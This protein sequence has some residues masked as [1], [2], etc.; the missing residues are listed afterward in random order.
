M[1]RLMFVKGSRPMANVEVHVPALGERFETD[2]QGQTQIPVED[3]E[4]EVRIKTDHGFLEQTVTP[5]PRSSMTVVNVTTQAGH[6]TT[7]GR[8]DGYLDPEMRLGDRYEYVEHLGRGG[9]AVVV[10]ARDTVLER[11]VAIKILSRDLAEFEEAREIFMTEARNLATLSHSNLVPVYDVDSDGGR[12]MMITEYVQ[13][14]TLE[15]LL[16]SEAALPQSTALRIG[17]QLSRAVGY[18]HEEGT[19]HRDLKPANIMLQSDGTLKVIDFGLARSVQRLADRG[20]QI[21]GT[22]AYMAPEQ[23]Q[24]D[25]L[26]EGVDIYQIGVTMFETISGKL[27]FDGGDLAYAHVHQEPPSLADR[28]P[29]VL[30]GLADVVDACLAKS[31][32][33]RPGSAERLMEEYDRL[34]GLLTSSRVTDAS[35]SEPNIE[36]EEVDVEPAA[37]E[38]EVVSDGEIDE[39]DASAG[40]RALAETRAE[41]PTGPLEEGAGENSGG[42]LEVD[43]S[44]SGGRGLAVVAAL[45]V[46]GTAVVVV[47]WAWK[48]AGGSEGVAGEGDE[49]RT[50]AAAAGTEAGGGASANR[51]PDTGGSGVA[52][53]IPHA[54]RRLRAALTAGQTAVGHPVVS[55][56]GTSDE[57]SDTG[58]AGGSPGTVQ[59]KAGAAPRGRPADPSAGGKRDSSGDGEAASGSSERAKTASPSESNNEGGDGQAE[60]ADEQRDAPSVSDRTGNASDAGSSAD[61]SSTDQPKQAETERAETSDQPSKLDE[62]PEPS[63]GDE[64]E[65]PSKF[66]S[67]VTSGDDSASNGGAETDESTEVSGDGSEEDDDTSGSVQQDDSGEEETSEGADGE[68]DEPENPP[69]SF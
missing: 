46:V 58:R 18:L 21:R 35:L 45:I 16:Q 30:P 68:T 24:G 20:T 40:S 53:V 67:P 14:Q 34:R 57:V 50:P 33:E 23:I 59:K 2:Q 6:R 51:E 13:G 7:G 69:V 15:S 28:A 54:E 9:M 1:M 8:T 31:P 27:P 61:A 5:E 17:V 36:G 19:I 42:D 11:A 47:S 63:G 62:K 12:P 55:K 29:N 37:A 60:G 38:S 65:S 22:P 39:S 49:A 66:D 3:S 56:K 10:Q 41:P 25:D 26:G 48:W 52:E 44:A 43:A 4:F 64:V 32:S